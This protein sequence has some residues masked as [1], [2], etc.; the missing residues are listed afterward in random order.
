MCLLLFLLFLL[1]LLFLLFLL[2]SSFFLVLPGKWWM[3]TF[4]SHLVN[5][6][7]VHQVKVWCLW[8]HHLSSSLLWRRRRH[9]AR[10]SSSSEDAAG[11]TRDRSSH[12]EGWREHVVHVLNV[13][14]KHMY[15]NVG[16]LRLRNQIVKY[17][18]RT[19]RRT[20]SYF[21]S[22][23]SYGHALFTYDTIRDTLPNYCQVFTRRWFSRFWGFGRKIP[24]E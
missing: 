15:R 5:D 20:F 9:A 13:E 8:L 11:R 16:V 19:R 7:P 3:N 23:K 1:L 24:E 6:L 21:S 22:G 18:V 12:R 4:N 10:I 2:F 14:I 17:Q